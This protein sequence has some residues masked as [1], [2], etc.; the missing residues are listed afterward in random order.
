MTL[1]RTDARLTIVGTLWRALD[2]VQRY[3]LHVPRWCIIA[4]HKLVYCS[5]TNQI[6]S[7]LLF[8]IK[9]AY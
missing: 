1:K 5:P 7:L 6:G 2:V 8:Y 9:H 4:A 3:A